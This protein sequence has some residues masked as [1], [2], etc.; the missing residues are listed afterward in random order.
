MSIY[1]KLMAVR[2]ALY[3]QELKKEGKAHNRKYF[4]LEDFLKPAMKE[5]DKQGLCGVVSFSESLATLTIHD[6]EKPGE[7]IVVTCPA[8]TAKLANCHEVQNLGAV[9]SYQRRYLWLTALEIVESDLLEES[10]GPPQQKPQA[11]PKPQGPALPPPL[12]GQTPQAS[13]AQQEAKELRGAITAILKA[14]FEGLTKDEVQQQFSHITGYDSI[15]VIANNPAALLDAQEKLLAHFEQKG[16][17]N[18]AAA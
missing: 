12:P 6:A 11:K 1:K 17:S 8:S 18:V 9:M 13:Q 2:L 3:D 15:S 7:T 14:G 10:Q 16:K 5:M 4:S